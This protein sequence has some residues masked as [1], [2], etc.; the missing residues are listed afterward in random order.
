MGKG[1]EIGPIRPPSEASSLL[2]RIT[3][4]CSWN[5]CK[6]CNLY[7]DEKF[8]TR[9][10]E[11]IKADIDQVALLRNNIMEWTKTNNIRD[12]TRVNKILYEKIGHEPSEIVQRYRNVLHWLNRESDSVFLQDANTVALSF[13]KLLEI[14]LYLKE[15]LPQVKRVTSYG[16]VDSLAKFSIAEWTQLREAG[17]N[18]IHSGYESGSDKVL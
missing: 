13:N 17:L 11:E 12:L 3:R 2:L 7:R 1:F 18:R 4:N 10:M 15:K 16:R 6:F 8:S 9:P 5:R 14:L